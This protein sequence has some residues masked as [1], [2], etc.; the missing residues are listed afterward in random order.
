VFSVTSKV[1][2]K[3]LDGNCKSGL[4][5]GGF[6]LKRINSIDQFVDS[7]HFSCLEALQGQSQL[8]DICSCVLGML[9]ILSI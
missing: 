7:L 4:G 1:G 2:V 9:A 8:S 3:G 5:R 6:L